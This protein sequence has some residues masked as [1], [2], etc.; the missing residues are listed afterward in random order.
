MRRAAGL[1]AGV[2]SMAAASHVFF[3]LVVRPELV[4][5][6][7]QPIFFL[8][9][10]FFRSF[11]AL[12]GGLLA[13]IAAFAGQALFFP[14][15]GATLLLLIFLCGSV[16]TLRVLCGRASGTALE[17]LFAAALAF[18]F[19]MQCQYE[20]NLLIGLGFILQ[21]AFFLLYARSGN[22]GRFGSTAAFLLLASLS[23][24]L[25]G[26]QHF[27]FALLCLLQAC[28]EGR[29]I[30]GFLY[31]A[32][33]AAIAVLGSLVY[34]V[35]L[36]EAFSSS[37]IRLPAMDRSISL[38]H[39]GYGIL[40]VLLVLSR[41]L[42]FKS[43][44]PKGGRQNRGLI[45]STIIGLAGGMLAVLL[46]G[47]TEIKQILKIEL[48]SGERKWTEVLATAG[49]MKKP[50]IRAT[51]QVNRALFHLGRL[52]ED[53]FSFRQTYGTSG[54]VFSQAL[55]FQMPFQR[56]DIFL[57]LGHVNEAQHWAH[58]ETAPIGD[59]PENL[60]V[61]AMANLAKG[62]YR[63]A[64][65]FL[66]SLRK[67]IPYRRWAKRYPVHLSSHVS[68]D[69]DSIIGRITAQMPTS[70]FI[71]NLEYPER[72]LERLLASNPKNRMVFEYLMAHYLL[73]CRLGRLV[74][75]I[76]RLNDFGYE[77]IPR[78]YEEALLV[79]LGQSGKSQ[80]EFCGRGISEKTLRRFEEFRFVI[81]KHRGDGKAAESELRK[82]FAGTYWIYSMFENP[83]M[84]GNP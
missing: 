65:L 60:K 79:Y 5:Q 61:L 31:A 66:N 23:Y 64:N 41:F 42:R 83:L 44:S 9:G 56:R 27:Y 80:T 45:A 20:H 33:A 26:A 67:T 24:A 52:S 81:R 34:G 58:E 75:N 82:R 11:A 16:L 73:T 40:P 3:W 39:A 10:D 84:A 19:L 68:A 57:D 74:Q 25:S 22:T 21:L 76:C 77:G 63:A 71:V 46:A 72:D 28:F 47:E 54:L 15:I 1:T 4:F 49:K 12:P 29:I 53:M 38:C 59:H 50:H 17:L 43:S 18:L 62:Q 13:Y 51:W 78:H 14:A 35:G 69:P 7:Q 32:I 6:C 37:I 8:D 70:D 55:S 48:A 30:R 2:L 36:A